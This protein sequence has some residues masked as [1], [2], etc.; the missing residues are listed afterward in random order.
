V[1]KRVNMLATMPCRQT[2]LSF[3]NPPLSFDPPSSK[4]KRWMSLSDDMLL[5]QLRR[6]DEQTAIAVEARELLKPDYAPQL[7]L[8]AGMMHESVSERTPVHVALASLGPVWAARL[9]SVELMSSVM[10]GHAVSARATW[11]KALSRVVPETSLRVSGECDAHTTPPPA[12]P[13][14]SPDAIG[15]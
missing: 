11:T 14:K 6:A 5:L 9:Q 3:L 13:F 7:K 12:R 15:V 8:L 10:A 2:A 4:A 1:K